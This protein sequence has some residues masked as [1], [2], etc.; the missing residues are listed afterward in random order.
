[1]LDRMLVDARTERPMDAFQLNALDDLI[2]SEAFPLW[3][4]SMQEGRPYPNLVGD[5]DMPGVWGG[6]VILFE[7]QN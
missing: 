5:L 6:H 4:F 1:M 7:V 2:G 3:V